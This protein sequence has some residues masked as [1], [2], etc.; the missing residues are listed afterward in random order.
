MG[1]ATKLER[2]SLGHQTTGETDE[3]VEEALSYSS[4][5]LP[6]SSTTEM[7]HS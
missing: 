1:S 5:G 4:Q 2:V 7:E 6:L 3:T